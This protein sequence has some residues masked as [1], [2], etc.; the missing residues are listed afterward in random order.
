[1]GGPP[2]PPLTEKIRY[3]VFDSFPYRYGKIQPKEI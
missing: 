1:M 3:V 2:A